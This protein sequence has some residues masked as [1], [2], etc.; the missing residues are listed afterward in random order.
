MKSEVKSEV[1]V[2]YDYE[3]MASVL[4]YKDKAS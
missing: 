4:E 1:A 3:S 2:V